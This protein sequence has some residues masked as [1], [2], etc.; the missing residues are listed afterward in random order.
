MIDSY[1]GYHQIR[2]HPDDVA[3]TAFGVCCGVFGFESMLFELK[4]TGATYPKM[5][6]V[7]KDQIG[8]NMA[9]YVDD[10]LVKSQRAAQHGEHLEKIFNVIRAYRL[11]LNTAK[12][13]FGVKVEKFLGYMVK[14]KGIEVNQAKVAALMR[15]TPPL[16]YPRGAGY[17]W[18]NSHV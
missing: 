5:D 12:C 18:K 13:T 3:K 14:Q 7:F 6:T 10:M 15:M 17:K 4:I 8:K 11:M 1:Q 2:M 16:E 9:V